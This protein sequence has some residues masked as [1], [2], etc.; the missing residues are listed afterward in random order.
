MLSSTELIIPTI[1][2][3]IGFNFSND[4]AAKAQLLQFLSQKELLLI[5]DN[6]EHL[7]EGA[8]IVL[9]ILEAAPKCKILVTS[10]ESLNFQGE[11][12]YELS[13]LNYPQDID[14]LLE[15]YDAIRLFY[16]LS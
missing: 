16:K 11:H 3:A 2:D 12:L 1:A 15:D 9:D 7:M 10:R 14:D 4:T 8:E 6:F 13:G 5:L